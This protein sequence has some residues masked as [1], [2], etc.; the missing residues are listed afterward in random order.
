MSR[1]LVTGGNGF[2]G[3]ALIRELAKNEQNEIMS[4]DNLSNGDYSNI[5]CNPAVEY[6]HCDTNNI[7]N[8]KPSRA[9]Q[10]NAVYHLGEYSR[11]VPSFKDVRQCQHSI[12]SG[13]FRLLEYCREHNSKLI[14]AG[15]SSKFGNEG[16]DEHLSPYAWW[17]AKNTELINNYHR[18]WGLDFSIAY[19]YNVYGSGQISQGDMAT[20]IGIF[21]EQYKRSE[22]L[23]VVS[24]G[25]QKRDLL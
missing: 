15:S 16:E 11:I 21:Q 8:H 20:V 4:I 12:G 9:F 19:F 25:L 17:K 2:I 1:I 6:Y 22:P 18:W 10:P 3:S 23:T 14:Y 24:P 13:T 7:L 5:T